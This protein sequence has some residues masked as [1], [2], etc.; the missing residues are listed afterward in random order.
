MYYLIDCNQFFVSCEQVFNPKLRNRPVVVLSSNDGCI[1]AR[2]KEAKALGIPMG[3]P[4]F[5]HKEILLRNGV[6]CLSSNFALYADMS[7]RVMEVLER[8][9][10]DL[11]VYSIDEAF[12]QNDTPNAV[13]FAEEIRTTV[14]R[15]TGI[16][17]S[18]G[19]GKTKT[20]SK[21]ASDLAKKEKNGVFLFDDE[22]VL[23]KLP[24]DEVWGIGKRLKETLA[25][26][27]IF[28]AW[29]LANAE[30]SWLKKQCSVALVRTA[31]EL[32]G[33]PCFEREESSE[34][35]QSSILRSRSFGR[36]VI[37]LSEIK[38]ALAMHTAKAAVKLREQETLASVCGVF[39]VTTQFY[40]S[41]SSQALS[42][43]TSYTPH[44]IE[45]AQELLTPLFREGTKYRK[46]GVCFSELISNKNVQGDF[47][48]P[49]LKTQ[50]K[51]KKA[52]DVVD[53]IQRQFGSGALRFAAEGLQQSWK[54][55]Q[56]KRSPR[57][58]TCWEE[59]L[60]IN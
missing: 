47:W 57:Y 25:E 45:K 13:A 15:W 9:S 55:K 30:P 60:E 7:Q 44:L 54:R 49:A 2:S 40:N 43:P 26:L 21:L 17:V 56:D 11:E 59:L 8:F 41:F 33:T 3:A 36:P 42:T 19:I 29:E 52:M 5:Q 14:L 27:G 50:E 31:L 34:E 58:T 39:L 48:Q 10:S 35:I 51:Q 46:V 20:L 28:S 6:V 23:K 16:L 24:V 32:R 38:E 37:L 22:N 18:I 1:V 12:L 4:A 53:E